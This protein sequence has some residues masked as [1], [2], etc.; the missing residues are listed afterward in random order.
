MEFLAKAAKE[1]GGSYAG[2]KEESQWQTSTK[3]DDAK[4]AA[5]KERE[6]LAQRFAE[7]T[8]KPKRSVLSLK[9]DD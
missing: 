1:D 4:T 7:R 8:D 5:I 9:K 3:A 2:W 6:A